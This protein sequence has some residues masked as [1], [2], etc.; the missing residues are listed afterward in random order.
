M[1][2]GDALA[3]PHSFQVWNK[4]T[5]DIQIIS[6][7]QSP[8]LVQPEMKGVKACSLGTELGIVLKNKT[9]IFP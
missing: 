6:S 3:V 8:L 7:P 1:T 4:E 5:D 2:S 9:L